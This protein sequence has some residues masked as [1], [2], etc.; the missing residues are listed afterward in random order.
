ML[1]SRCLVFMM[2][3]ALAGAGSIESASYAGQG[4]KFSSA[5]T[6]LNS[7]CKA[8]ARAAEGQDTPMRCKGYGGY[9]IY[10]FYSAWASN[11]NADAAKG[12]VS[13]PLAMQGLSYSEEKGRKVEWRLAGGKPFAV[14]MRVSNYK[15]DA[16]AE[17]DSPYQEKYKTGESLIVKGLKG[18]ESIDFKVDVKTT[19]NPNVRAREMADEA[20]LKGQ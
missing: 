13:I 5:Y 17:G 3:A 2:V 20:Y 9:S 18:Y 19:L 7:E 4:P 16:G 14:I 11:I 1:K 10:I 8:A 6:D 12:E 15:E